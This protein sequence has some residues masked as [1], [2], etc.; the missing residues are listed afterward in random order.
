M[1]ANQLETQLH[2]WHGLNGGKATLINL[3]EN[4]T[5]RIDMPDASKHII[6]VHRPNY[7]TFAA[8]NSELMWLKAL[9]NGTVLNLIT[10]LVGINENLVQQVKTMSGNISHAVRFAFEKGQEADDEKDEHLFSDLGRFAAIC[11]NHVQ[12]W[13]TPKGFSR[14][15]WSEGAILDR[16]GL[17]GDWR[18]A[19]NVNGEVRAVL[20]QLDFRLRE[21]LKEYGTCSK[22]FGLIH[23]DMRL[24]NILVY[25]NTSRLIDFDDC[26]FGWFAYD[27]AAA[28]SFFE[29][30]KKV[31]FLKEKWLSAYRK[32]REFSTTDETMMDTLIM[33]RRMAL[34]T[35]I[36]SHSE[37]DLAKSLQ[38][39]FAK[40]S[41]ILAKNYLNGVL[42]I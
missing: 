31:P 7:Q 26:G 34:L 2:L 36:G 1:Q 17:W 38:G 15:I 42:Y 37:T 22:H 21:Q 23:A 11:H 27:F 40:N 10:P 5:F 41:A 28:I 3:S 14:P 4:H 29:D 35:W 9:K 18:S 19:P 32:Y 24:A 12:Q 30:S 25:N 33:L 20:E 39:D 13:E 6:R 8:I 16:D